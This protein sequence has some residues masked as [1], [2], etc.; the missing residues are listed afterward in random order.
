MAACLGLVAQSRAQT[1]PIRILPLGDSITAGFAFNNWG[2][3]GGNADLGIGNNPGPTG[4]PDWTFTGNANGYS[5]KSL[6]VLVNP[7]A[8][9]TNAAGGSWNTGAN[10]TDNIIPNAVGANADL[11]TLNLTGN[12]AVTI[13]GSKTVGQLNF[14]DTTPGNNWS[15]NTGSGGELTLAVGSGV[16]AIT[17]INQTATLNAILAGTQG[18]AKNG[19]GILLVTGANSYTGATTVNA[20]SIYSSQF[21]RSNPNGV[22]ALTKV[23]TGTLTLSGLNHY[24]GATTVSQGALQVPGSLAGSAVTVAAGSSLGGTG[25]IGGPVTVAGTLAPGTAAIGTL[26]ISNTLTAAGTVAMRIGK[27]GTTCLNDQVKGISTLNCGG[28]LVVTNPGAAALVAGDTFRLFVAGGYAGTFA[29]VALPPL[30][31]G[32]AWDTSNLTFSGILSVTAP[33]VGNLPAG[34]SATGIG[35]T[36]IPGAASCNGPAYGVS[37]SGAAIGGSADAFQFS[38][39]ALAG[40]GEIKARVVSQTITNG[41]AM[42]GVM[43][44]SGSGAGAVNALV[45]LTPNGF[46]NQARTTTNGPTA[47]LASAARHV[48][49]DNW[50]PLLR[51]GTTV[52]AY[53]S[54]DGNAW[55]QLGSCTMPVGTLSVGLAVTSHDNT[56][57]STVTYDHVVVLDWAATTA[58]QPVLDNRLLINPGKGFVEYWGPTTAYTNDVIGVGYNRC[59]W[60]TLEP[61][62]GVYNCG[63]SL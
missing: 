1:A 32:L 47:T 43:M 58:V 50:L 53:V 59:G 15:V 39:Q 24:N 3:Y 2:G 5:V 52:T 31:W 40:D 44:R 36:G 46:T 51:I 6:Q 4:E 41:A 26:T 55:F 38:A 57:L 29:S 18:L 27:S 10:W 61:A 7:V 54:A 25:T 20:G 60:S 45:A 62:E 22:G 19:A 9:W 13:D 56:A 21:W 33:V 28:A 16:P 35:A 14:G 63:G 8:V 30:D 23:G 11:S 34:W 37:G 49:P 42:A 48:A 17:V 12:A